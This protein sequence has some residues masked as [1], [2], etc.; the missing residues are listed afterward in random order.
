MIKVANVYLA[1]NGTYLASFLSGFADADAA[2]I[3]L[4]QLAGKSLD[5]TTARNGIIIA[6]MTNIASK[7]AI[8]FWLG[9]R[10]F[11]KMLVGLFSVLI[12]IGIGFVV[13][14]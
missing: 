12:V 1:D 4:S 5:L 9:G 8:G 2:T 10:E 13:L 11:G 3:S 14:F 7:G 6:V